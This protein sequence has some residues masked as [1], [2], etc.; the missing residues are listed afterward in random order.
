MSLANYGDLELTEVQPALLAKEVT[1]N[2][3]RPHQALRYLTPKQFVDN[4]KIRTRKEESV[5]NHM[6]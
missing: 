6:S 4:W 5:T 2:T 1:Y 3:A